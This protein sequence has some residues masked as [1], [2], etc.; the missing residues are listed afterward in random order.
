MRELRE[1]AEEECIQGLEEDAYL[2]SLRSRQAVDTDSFL[3]PISNVYNIVQSNASSPTVTFRRHRTRHPPITDTRSFVSVPE[4][5]P[6]QKGGNVGRKPIVLSVLAEDAIRYIFHK[7]LEE[8]IYPTIAT[9]LARLLAEY[10]DFPIRTES[11][12]LKKMKEIGFQYRKTATVRIA[13]DSI[14]FM[15][16]RAT[17]FQSIDD[18]RSDNA[19]IYYYD[20]TWSNVGDE[21]RSIWL[22]DRG[23]GRLRKNDGKG[24][25]LAISAMINNHAIDIDTIDTFVCDEDHTMNSSHFIEWLRKAAEHLRRKYCNSTR[26]CI[27][28][29]NARWHNELCDDAK[30]PKRSW[31]KSEIEQWLRKRKIKYEICQKKAQLF[32]LAIA[33][34]PPKKFKADVVAAKFNVQLLRLPV[35]HSMLNPVELLWAQ[36]KEHIRKNNT[37]FRLSDIKSLTIDFL[38]SFTSD[39]C[40]KLIQHVR[41]VEET[42]RAADELVEEQLEPSLI[43]SDS[44]GER[45]TNENLEDTDDDDM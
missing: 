40:G 20:E 15:S 3:A 6:P 12:L 2:Y 29:D 5:I 22:S 31:R 11:T 27:V 18:L 42:F 32:E 16:Q 39:S 26:I 23:E 14:T 43:D 1:Q 24:K 10:S 8:K 28:L 17:Y 33:N 45:D 4:P 38:N 30:P 36:L 7:M 44:D 35:K 37:S 9:L 34:A 21:K 41:G 19:Q 25:R 13:L